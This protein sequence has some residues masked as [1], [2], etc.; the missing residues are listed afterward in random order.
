MIAKNC[1]PAAPS[2]PTFRYAV[3]T[4]KSTDDGS[5]QEFHLLDAQRDAGESYIKSHVAEGWQCLAERYDDGGFASLAGATVAMA[6]HR[7]ILFL[8]CLRIVLAGGL[9]AP[10]L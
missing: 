2:A 7:A 9:R 10:C 6:I 1:K 8:P 4:R 3:Y 5:E